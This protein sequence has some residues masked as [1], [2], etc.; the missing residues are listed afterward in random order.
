VFSTI[1]H[2]TDFSEASIPALRTAHDLAKALNA[3]LL[4]CFIANPPL[5]ASGDTLTDPK[6]GES[7]NVAEE[8][9]QNQA[10]D[11]A[12]KRE[13]RIVMTEK[14]TRVKTLLGF[15]SDMGCDLLVLGMHNKSGIA[16]WLGSSIT[17]EVVRQAQCAVMVVK[18]HEY[19]F[20]S[21]EGA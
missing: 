16:G 11:P 20:Q 21:E 15:L 12:V 8:L 13:L 1:V 4:V 3:K 10:S 6:T 17:E 19:E 2:P 5:I 14:S 9:E 7:R 18:H